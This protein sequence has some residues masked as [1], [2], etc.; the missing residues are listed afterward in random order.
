[1]LSLLLQVSHYFSTSGGPVTAQR[2]ILRAGAVWHPVDLA[3]PDHTPARG[4][5]S[6]EPARASCGSAS[7]LACGSPLGDRRDATPHPP[8]PT[9]AVF[10]AGHP[11]D[12]PARRG[13]CLVGTRTL[14]ESRVP[15]C[16][17]ADRHAAWVGRCSYARSVR[18]YLPE[19]VV[20]REFPQ[21]RAREGHEPRSPTGCRDCER[22]LSAGLW[23]T[24]SGCVL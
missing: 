1:M 11:G 16:K 10:V 17:G 8:D 9:A 18:F 7:G 13:H 3:Q 2:S 21:E 15:P 22:L 24:V 12:L 4:Q 6:A 20:P 5:P 23:I 19:P 14:S